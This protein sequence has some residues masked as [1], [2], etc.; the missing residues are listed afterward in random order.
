MNHFSHRERNIVKSTMSGWLSP[1][2]HLD[3]LADHLLKPKLGI[4]LYNI[5][6]IFM[7]FQMQCLNLNDFLFTILCFVSKFGWFSSSVIHTMHYVHSVHNIYLYLI[8]IEC[9]MDLFYSTVQWLICMQAV[10][11][12]KADN[13]NLNFNATCAAFYANYPV[14]SGQHKKKT[15]TK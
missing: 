5:T 2:L 14:F 11:V 8:F 6:H 7:M 3:C 1:D 10:S 12:C 15:Q 9:I 13:Q 4:N